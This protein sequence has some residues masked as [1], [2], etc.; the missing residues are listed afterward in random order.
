MREE[1]NLTRVIQ[2][3]T[4]IAPDGKQVQRHAQGV[5]DEMYP[6]VRVKIPVNR[7]FADGKTMPAG[8]EQYLGIERHTVH[9][10]QRED[11][12]SAISTEAF[13]TALSI[14]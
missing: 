10:L 2:A 1:S 4:G 11:S 7:H 3:V 14:L 6:A 8:D 9:A 12:L 5:F 13:K